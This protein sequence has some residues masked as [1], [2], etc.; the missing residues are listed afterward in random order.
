MR[1]ETLRENH[2]RNELSNEIIEAI[3]KYKTTFKVDNMYI[4]EFIAYL[5]NVEIK[6][7]G[8]TIENLKDLVV[9]YKETDVYSLLEIYTTQENPNASNPTDNE[10]LL[11]EFK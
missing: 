3:E 9:K 8:S 4:L 5:L 6:V 7:N 11:I 10:E 2:L 1:N